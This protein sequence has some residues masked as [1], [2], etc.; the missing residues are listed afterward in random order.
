MRLII[1]ISAVALLLVMSVACMFGCTKQDDAVETEA[2]YYTVKFNTSGGTEIEDMRVIGGGKVTKPPMPERDGYIF[3]GWREGVKEWIFDSDTV[4]SDITLTAS[5]ISATSVFEIEKIDED[6]DKEMDKVVLTKYVGSLTSFTLPKVID[7]IPV[8][9]IGDRAFADSSKDKLSAIVLHENIVSLGVSAFEGC[10]GVS[11]TV[12]G[13]LTSIGERS[14]YG[15][16]GLEDITIGRGVEKIPYEAFS[17]CVSLKSVV[18]SDTVNAI[19][20]NAFELCSSLKS[21]IL[22][23]SVRTV[24]DS[25]FN[26]C[27]ELG[28]I[29]YYGTAEE[30]DATE[31]AEG[32]NGNDA[33]FDAKFYVY[34]ET[35]PDKNAEGEY[36][37]FDS[38]GKTRVW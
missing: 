5:W 20:E 37:Y 30:W 1:K 10:S 27:T 11:I 7:G 32:N 23:S 33:L 17:G 2:T 18:L 15:C 22:Y 36:W 26:D 31:I 24:G 28:S 21:I 14:F 6:G 16:D 35:E 4:K 13:K 12:E 38:K 29:F 8:T 3:N 19:E 25:A 9:A 34:S